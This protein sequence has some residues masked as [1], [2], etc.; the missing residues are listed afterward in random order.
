MV[1]SRDVD[2]PFHMMTPRLP[3]LARE[4]LLVGA[5]RQNHCDAKKA[6]VYVKL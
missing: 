4:P 1:F 2:P 3:H 6:D 5:V